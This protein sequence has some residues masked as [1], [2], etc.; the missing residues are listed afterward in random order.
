MPGKIKIEKGKVIFELKGVDKVLAVKSRLTVPIEHIKSVS[1]KKADWG[2]LRFQLRMGGTGIPLL[3]K[4]GRYWDRR[5]GWLFYVMR[6]PKRCVTVG[7]KNE[8]YKKIIF[9]VEDKE[10]TAKKLLAYLSKS[11]YGTTGSALR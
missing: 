1:T 10:K 5:R 6:H 4:N 7:L 3:V 9:E 2:F 8:R 11:G